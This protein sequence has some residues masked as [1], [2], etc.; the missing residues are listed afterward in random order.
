MI[1]P[2][3]EKALGYLVDLEIA[4]STGSALP[5]FSQF[6]AGKYPRKL[7][8]F[9]SVKRREY[10]ALKKD[11]IWIDYPKTFTDPEDSRINLGQSG[12]ADE[13]NKSETQ[14]T[15]ALAERFWAENSDFFEKNGF[16]H[17]TFVDIIISADS[18]DLSLDNFEKALNG[19]ATDLSPGDQI[20]ILNKVITPLK[21]L[22]SEFE[23]LNSKVIGANR[24][25]IKVCCLTQ[26][27]DNKK[28]WEDYAAQYSGFVIE[29]SI[30]DNAHLSEQDKNAFSSLFP[31]SYYE[32]IPCADI[33]PLILDAINGKTISNISDASQ[34][35]LTETIKQALSKQSEYNP[36][37]EWRLIRGKEE[38]NHFAF[39][40]A[41]AVYTGYK[42]KRHNYAVLRNICKSKGLSLYR[43]QY[44]E[45]MQ[46][47][48]YQ[49]DISK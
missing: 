32:S 36:E 6:D 44:D 13:I 33:S 26:T 27:Y 39:P 14:I 24:N 15:V 46:R 49:L 8:R 1:D 29:Y 41:T 18:A 38:D 11:Y 23:N 47:L 37:Q 25:G 34:R 40:Y 31:V 48:S 16:D 3:F 22:E 43:Q 5:A 42:I 19:I 28:M 45:R 30:P 17:K 4:K 9:R 21:T 12:S 20:T 10:T 7:Y 2:Y 35:F